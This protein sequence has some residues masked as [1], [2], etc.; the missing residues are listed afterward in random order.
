VVNS[1]LSDRVQ[2][3][4]HNGSF[5]PYTAVSVGAPQGTKLGPIL[6]LIYSNDISFDGFSKVQYADD[7]TIYMPIRSASENVAQGIAQA[8]QWSLSN[9]MLLNNSKTVILNVAFAEHLGIND[10]VTYGGTDIHPADSATF[11]GLTAGKTLTFSE[12]ST[13]VASKCN[14]RLHL[15]RQL[16]QKGI[17]SEGLLTFYKTHVK[18]VISYAAPAW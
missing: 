14:P 15:M 13:N 8:Q 3:V 2:C 1:F 7:T 18:A 6:W 4:K 5:S 12:H 10:P 17:N 11:L 9:N 16:R